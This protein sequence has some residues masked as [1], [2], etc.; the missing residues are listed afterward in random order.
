MKNC[1]KFLLE[2]PLLDKKFPIVC[3][4]CNTKHDLRVH[5]VA[6]GTPNDKTMCGLD[7]KELKYSSLGMNC[8][9]PN[10][11]DIVQDLIDKQPPTRT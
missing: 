5:I 6:S 7:K 11:G 4:T 2:S 8:T 3:S 10:C 1:C 9:C